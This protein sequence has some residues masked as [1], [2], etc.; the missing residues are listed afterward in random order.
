MRVHTQME[1][2]KV[3]DDSWEKRNIIWLK[4]YWKGPKAEKLSMVLY[5]KK[6]SNITDIGLFRMFYMLAMT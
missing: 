1:K 4:M 3:Q 2:L 5:L 6:E